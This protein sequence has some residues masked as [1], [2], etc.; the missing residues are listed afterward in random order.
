MRKPSTLIFLLSTML[1]TG[2]LFDT[3]CCEHRSTGEITP[4]LYIERYL[5]FCGGVFGGELTT[6]Y[7][8]DSTV[9]RQPIG[10]DDEHE[11]LGCSI[12]GDILYT[13][14]VESR[15]SEYIATRKFFTPSQLSAYHHTPATCI[16]TAPLFGSNPIACDSD[17]Y[18][19]SSYETFKGHHITSVQYKCGS[20]YLNAQFFTDSSK[21]CILLDI[22]DVG[23]SGNMYRVENKGDTL[24][25]FQ[26]VAFI[27]WVDTIETETFRISALK[28]KGFA[29]VCK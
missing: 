8:T 1:L 29:K 18:D 9:F 3:D 13:H 15:D 26:E 11:F 6:S 21:F 23:K 17:F 10:S 12:D 2:C 4:G 7:L 19:F 5:T 16:G 27:H 28:K 22:D 24:F 14:L 20:D 25:E